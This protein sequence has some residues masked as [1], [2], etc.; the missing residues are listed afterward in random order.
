MAVLDWI[1]DFISPR[2]SDRTPGQPRVLAVPFCPE[3][4]GYWFVE[5][6]ASAGS[7]TAV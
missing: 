3:A 1:V 2:L 6:E 4:Y 7:D 5:D